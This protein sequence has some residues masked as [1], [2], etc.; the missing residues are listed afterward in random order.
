MYCLLSRSEAIVNDATD[1][2]HSKLQKNDRNIHSVTSGVSKILAKSYR[3]YVVHKF[4]FTHLDHFLLSFLGE[5][6]A[7][8]TTERRQGV[9]ILV[10]W[11][12]K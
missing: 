5:Y 11:K 4:I 9:Y 3:V 6:I 10:N 1:D 7:C 8:E 12:G 2:F